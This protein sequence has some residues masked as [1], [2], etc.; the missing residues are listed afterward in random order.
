MPDNTH[1][2]FYMV[3]CPDDSL[4]CGIA[5]DPQAR[6]KARNAARGADYTARR[7]PVA[8]AYSEAHPTE[9]AAGSREMEVK[10]WRAEKKEDLVRGFPSSAS[11]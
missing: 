11:G 1:W 4:Y 2:H 8:L 9:S 6:V 5:L 10:R 7:R 3:R